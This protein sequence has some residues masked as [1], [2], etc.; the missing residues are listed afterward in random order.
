MP[1]DH[2]IALLS[3]KNKEVT[4]YLNPNNVKC[5][6]SSYYKEVTRHYKECIEVKKRTV[7]LDDIFKE[8]CTIYDII[9][10][11]T[12][13]SELDIIKGGIKCIK[14]A[15][16]VILELSKKEYNEGSPLFEEVVMFMNKN[17]FN[18]YDVIEEHIWND[19]NENI[20]EIG[21]I[22]QVDVIFKKI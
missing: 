12:Q 9:K 4:F 10:I 8:T 20:F 16:Y 11:D 22:F 3:D 15:S 6:G 13:G 5:T 2:C 21:E 14:S 17:G 18:E 7:K 1:F 19:S